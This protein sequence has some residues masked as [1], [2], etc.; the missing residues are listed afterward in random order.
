MSIISFIKEA[1]EKLFGHK[2]LAPDA[3]A[4]DVAAKRMLPA[5]PVLL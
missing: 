5:W 3:P 2:T 1:G 4:V